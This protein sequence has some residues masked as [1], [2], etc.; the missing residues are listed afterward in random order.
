MNK[1]EFLKLVEPQLRDVF[2]QVQLGSRS[3]KAKHQCEGFIL[4]SS[5]NSAKTKELA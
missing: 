5:V 3:N 2:K 1:T 4:N